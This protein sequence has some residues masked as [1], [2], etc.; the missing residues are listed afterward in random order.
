MK[1]SLMRETKETRVDVS[2]DMESRETSISTGIELLDCVLTSLA[3]SAQMGLKVATHGDLT[4]GDHHTVEDVGITAGSALAG[5]IKGWKGPGNGCAI[6]P[7]GNVLA[8]AAI[9]FGEPGY[10]EEFS[11]ASEILGGMELENFSHFM[12]SLAYNGSFSLYLEAKGDDDRRKAEAM[13]AALGFALRAAFK[14]QW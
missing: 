11:F 5:L 1:T 12:R 14:K 13:A 6:V 10:L 9:R 8:T 3:Q 7:L 2:L 4:T